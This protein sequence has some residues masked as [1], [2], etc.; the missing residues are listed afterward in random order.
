MMKFIKF[1]L[2]T[3]PIIVCKPS[4]S[5]I[6]KEIETN[7]DTQTNII[8]DVEGEGDY[9]SKPN[10]G[11]SQDTRNGKSLEVFEQP[12]LAAALAYELEWFTNLTGSSKCIE[13]CG[14]ISKSA[15][16]VFKGEGTGGVLGEVTIDQLD[17]EAHFHGNI[18]GLSPGLHGFHVHQKG[19][20]GDD[21]KAA[22]GHFNP[23]GVNHGDKNDQVRHVGD[24]GNI[25]AG[26]DGIMVVDMK[27]SMAQLDGVNSIM[28]KAIVVHEGEDDLGLGGDEGS[29]K[30]GNAGARAGCCIIQQIVHQSSWFPQM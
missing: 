18:S 1:L 20:I 14:N 28:G 6:D 11:K 13:N 24:L 2:L 8:V 30:T 4:S 12:S 19:D 22:G 27:C 17:K 25:K 9:H 29:L 10:E 5:D 21:C 15:K 7:Q 3:L 23:E 26:E 16:C